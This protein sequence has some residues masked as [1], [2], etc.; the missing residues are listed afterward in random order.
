M[1][2]NPELVAEQ[3]YLDRVYARLREQRERA[4][5]L[6]S[7]VLLQKSV[8]PGSV[9]EREVVAEQTQLRMGQLDVG[10]LPICFGRIDRDNTPSEQGPPGE[11]FYIGRIGVWDEH[12]DPLV[13]DWRAPV[14]EPFYRA[15]GRHPMGLARRR[16][17]ACSGQ[18]IEA[19]EDEVFTP[20]AL[21]ASSDVEMVGAGALLAA[22]E[23]DR[24]G[25]MHDIVATVQREQDEIIRGSMHGVLVVQGGPGTGKTAVALHRAAYLLYTHRFPLE[26]QGVL[27]VGPNPLFLRYI[28]QVLPSLGETG[29][30]LFTVDGLVRTLPDTRINKRGGEDEAVARVKGDERMIRVLARAVK[31]RQ[32]PL[33]K[34]A[35]VPFGAFTLTLH[36]E[37]TAEVVNRVKR[38]PGT[39]NAR[40]RQVEQLLTQKL[41]AAHER[42]LEQIR[43]SVGLDDPMAGLVA[44]DDEV[45]ADHAESVK[46]AAAE[47]EREQR[48]RLAKVPEFV[49]VLDRMWPL[50]SPEELL[51]D[52]L[53]AKALVRLAGRGVLTDAECDLL[54]RPRSATYEEVPW[55]SADLA[56]ID[57]LR[58]KLGRP[59]KNGHAADD[60]IRQYGHVVVDEAQDL[61]PMQLRVLARRSLGSMT[62]V[63]DVAQASGHWAPSS[64]DQVLAHLPS[65]GH[66]ARIVELTV[67]YRT[68][69][70]IM[71]VA[72][73]V[74]AEAAPELHMPRSARPGGQPPRVVRADD[75][76]AAVVEAV[77]EETVLGGTLAVVCTPTEE[78]RLAAALRDAGLDFGE[79]E[80]GLDQPVALVPVVLAKGLEFDSV[81]VVEPTAI[82]EDVKF[83]LRA[84]FVALTRATKRVTILHS[85][86]LPPS[87]QRG[88]A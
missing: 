85:R 34:A 36:P 40:R 22:L 41:L 57:E 17:F 52:L 67:N 50:I 87:V 21:P 55:T 30:G 82:V 39:H 78:L 44:D 3:T 47:K 53:G 68:P 79:G 43:P 58:V 59:I 12:Q 71:D 6:L 18:H 11:T 38:R 20:D 14:A 74:L 42:A 62:I 81:I 75:L 83:G 76:A 27:V 16:H 45:D 28:D 60:E 15:T 88:L 49:A 56:L 19:I 25:R 84:L 24:T 8:T 77:R 80:E 33:A 23:R 35:R 66:E 9:V 72:A 63:G 51:H 13:I 61:S 2:A 32:R 5:E 46:E 54:V 26:R 4:S 69:G 1:A 64:W 73:A 48:V 86:E 37:E 65:I 70:A 31:D 10:R 29:V 7:E